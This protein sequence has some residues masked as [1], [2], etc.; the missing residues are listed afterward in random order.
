MT[1]Q[2]QTIELASLESLVVAQKSSPAIRS[3]QSIVHNP[4]RQV[5]AGSASSREDIGSGLGLERQ[6]V[7][8][9]WAWTPTY[10]IPIRIHC[11]G[12]PGGMVVPSRS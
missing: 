7:D 1:T 8:Q 6:V 2:L 12:S 11:T 3:P 10:L 5:I 9:K 4:Q